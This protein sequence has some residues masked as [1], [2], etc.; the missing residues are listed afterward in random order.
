LLQRG[1]QHG[2]DH[3]QC[4]E[5]ERDGREEGRRLNEGMGGRVEPQASIMID[6]GPLR[7]PSIG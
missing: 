2:R 1:L 7:Y 3:V 4:E 5:H 6:A